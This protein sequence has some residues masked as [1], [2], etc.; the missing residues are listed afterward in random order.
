VPFHRHQYVEYAEMVRHGLATV[1]P[2]RTHP[3]LQVAMHLS[4][5]QGCASASARPAANQRWPLPRPPTSGN[6]GG[7][8]GGGGGG[9]SSGGREGTVP[10]RLGA[11]E[12]Q[13]GFMGFGESE[14]EHE[15]SGSGAAEGARAAAPAGQPA[16]R[17][18]PSKQNEH[19][20]LVHSKVQRASC[21][22]GL[23]VVSLS[24]ESSADKHPPAPLPHFPHCLPIAIR[25]ARS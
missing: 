17:E 24:P 19:I 22:R 1:F 2:F 20:Y 25:P 18:R 5:H 9:N 4:A 14:E 23:A 13:I 11:L 3:Q 8:G 16:V 15:A 7:G 6:D 12:V 21:A 10:R